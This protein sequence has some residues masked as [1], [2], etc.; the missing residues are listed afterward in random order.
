MLRGRVSVPP[1]LGAFT[2]PVLLADASETLPDAPPTLGIF[3]T[4]AAPECVWSL[5]PSAWLD[6]IPRPESTPRPLSQPRMNSPPASGMRNVVVDKSPVE[7][8]PLLPANHPASVVML[9]E[10]AA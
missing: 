2:N 4:T 1:P 7:N 6:P 5:N 10:A 8:E 9:P 3:A